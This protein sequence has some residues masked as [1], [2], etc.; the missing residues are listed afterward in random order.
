M[1]VPAIYKRMVLNSCYCLGKAQ[2][3]VRSLRMCVCVCGDCG[4]CVVCV[5]VHVCVFGVCVVYACM[6]VF[7]PRC[8]VRVCVWF[9]CVV[10]VCG[11]CVSVCTWPIESYS[12]AM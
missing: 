1:F 8:V 9:V 12:V 10:Y 2:K 6:C 7:G 11:V 3:A 5:C 4:V